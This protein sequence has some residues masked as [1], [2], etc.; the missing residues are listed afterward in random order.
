MGILTARQLE[1]NHDQADRHPRRAPQRTRRP[2]DRVNRWRDAGAIGRAV[3]KKPRGWMGTL[4]ARYDKAD[5]PAGACANDERREED[6][7]GDGGAERHGRQDRF[8]EGS[9]EKEGDE[10]FGFACAVVGGDTIRSR[11]RRGGKGGT[12]SHR[13]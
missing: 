8:D 13:P 5:C 6:A 9:N 1:Q 4:D 2:D 11:W 12:H 10:C 7:G 3:R